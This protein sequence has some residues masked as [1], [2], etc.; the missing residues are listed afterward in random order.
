MTKEEK[1]ISRREFISR[2]AGAAGA[3]LLGVFP[4]IASCAKADDRKPNIIFLFAD[5]MRNASLGCMGNTE[6]HT[7]NMD[8]LAGQGLLFT[9]AISGYPLCSPYRAML[10]TGRYGTSTGV[11]GNSVELPNTEIT[12]AKV[13]KERGYKTGFIGKWHLEKSHDPFVP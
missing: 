8:R 1:A 12:I 5:Q 13:L 2:S 3:A 10:L 11:V 9:N 6:V 4:S 7:P